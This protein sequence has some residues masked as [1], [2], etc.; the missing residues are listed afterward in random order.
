M[1]ETRL[2]GQKY[3]VGDQFTVTDIAML[4]WLRVA[5]TQP[6]GQLLEVGDKRNLNACREHVSTQPALV[7]GLR[8][9]SRSRPRSSLKA[10]SRR[11]R[12]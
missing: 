9:P 5:I 4:P 6:I 3:F 8:S 12:A 1:L 7:R 2:Q 11:E 10:S